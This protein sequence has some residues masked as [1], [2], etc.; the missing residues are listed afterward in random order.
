MNMTVL[1]ALVAALAAIFMLKRILT[2]LLMRRAGRQALAEVG[3]RALTKLPEYV[4]LSRV[5]SPDWTNEELVRQQAEPLLACAF[6]DAGVYSV[7]KMPGVLIRMMCQPQ[8]GVAAHIYDH[9]RSGSWIEMVTRYNDGST[10][11]VSTLAPNGMKHP[12]WFRKIQA[13][14]TI[15]TNKIYERFLPQRQ[16]HGIKL[17]ATNDVVRAFEEDYHKLALWRQEAGI[18]PQEVARVAVKWMKEKQVN[19]TGI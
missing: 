6:Q 3:K 8:S 18:S 12:E 19:A 7:N 2:Y 15:P 13:D 11:A 14:K 17:V 4:S 16:Q 1:L 10:H 9:P 5:E